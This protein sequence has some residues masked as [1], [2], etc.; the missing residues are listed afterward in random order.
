MANFLP[1][2]FEKLIVRTK[3]SY[4]RSK[5]EQKKSPIS[6][7]TTSFPLRLGFEVRVGTSLAVTCGF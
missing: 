1:L 2:W 7:Q 4:Q 6:H 5:K 3:F